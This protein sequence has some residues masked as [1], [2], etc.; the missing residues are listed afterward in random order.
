MRKGYVLCLCVVFIMA[1]QAAG[2][3]AEDKQPVTLDEMV[4]TAS[5]VEE[6][7]SKLSSNITVISRDDIEM[8][9]SRTV[10]GLMEE[11]NIGHIQK[12]PG[13]SISVGIR[14]FRTDTHGNDLQSH[15]LVLLD[16]RRAG[17]G[18]VAK[19]LTRNVERIEII[20][21]P[22][23]VQ[24]G[25]GGMGGVINIITRQGRADSAF[26][27]GGGGNFGLADGAIGGTAVLK[28][29]DFAGAVSAGTGGDYSDG[30][31][32]K[33]HNTGMDYR[34]GVSANTGYEF[35]PGHRL[36]MIFTYSKVKNAGNPGYIT[37]ND[38][39]DTTDK[40]NWSLDFK[41]TGEVP[42][43]TFKWMAR[44]FFGEDD[45]T[46]KD[47][48]ASNPDW[49]DDG[50]ASI[51]DTNQYGAQAQGT[52]TIGPATITAGFDWIKY[53]ITDTYEPQKSDYENPA[54]F[55]LSSASL[56]DSALTI[57]FGM[58]YDW[59]SVDVTKP[60][61]NDEDEDRFTPMVGLAWEAL[62]GLKFRFQYAQ[63]FM[64]P[65]A[66]QL[67]GYS[68]SPW[69]VTRGNP[70]LDPE[71]STTYE[72]GIDFMNYGIEASFTY[73]STSFDDKIQ[74]VYLPDGTGS[75]ENIGSAGID[76]L[77]V[78]LA[79]DIGVPLG[80]A[81]EIKPY[82]NMTWLTD[83]KDDDSD[84]RLKYTSAVNLSSGLAVSDGDRFSGR[85]NIAYTS[86]QDVD[87][88]Q[89]GLYPAPLSELDSFTV[90]DLMVT[91]RVLK[92]NDYG[93]LSWR[94]E[95]RN[96]FDEDYAYVKGYPMPGIN[97]YMGLR[98]DY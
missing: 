87:D 57:T 27:E 96:M 6:S 91:Y 32:N 40:K 14:G 25:S 50:E 39:D 20:R 97:F 48:V 24:Y 19:L 60:D 49:W 54:I 94:T 21:G 28:G 62:D 2:L 26:A 68:S 29:F 72:G 81:W 85:L 56:L 47:P 12:Y 78:A 67:G 30:N 90:V 37:Q 59:Y 41:Y 88:W 16:G 9:A 22:G 82:F 18:N 7:R 93:D 5:R 33:F 8:S 55:M 75:F 89:S 31:G 3:R 70:D 65:S 51:N 15:V 35:L 17:T 86:P 44:G 64:M 98:W 52:A 36:G 34:V 76:G 92:T 43:G 38:L 69:G 83:Y 71:K 11:K 13:A 23:A 46:W 4:V 95:V 80:L 66:W 10:G 73:F 61:G 74:S 1:A 45:N 42:D 63:G 84:D 77:E 79:Y 53:D 58:R